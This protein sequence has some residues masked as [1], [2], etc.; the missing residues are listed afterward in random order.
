MEVG[1]VNKRI[2]DLDAGQDCRQRR[3][4]LCLSEAL[5]SVLPILLS[6]LEML[7]R[8]DHCTLGNYVDDKEPVIELPVAL[9]FLQSSCSDNTTLDS[10]RA[11]K[12][13]PKATY[14]PDLASEAK[15]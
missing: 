10:I 12:A 14:R 1:V 11:S 2:G 7:I 13:P 4:M 9:H 8:R 6:N 3:A 5:I 15:A